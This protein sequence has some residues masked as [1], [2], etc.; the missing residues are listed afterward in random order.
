[1]RFIKLKNLIT[2][3]SG[4]GLGA[5]DIYNFYYLWYFVTTSPQ[6]VNTD[7][8][9]EVMKNYLY[10]LKNK[11]IVLFKNILAKQIAKYIQRNRVDGDFPKDIINSLGTLSS[12]ELKKLMAKTF[13]SDMK[14]RNDVWDMVAGFVYNLENATTSEKMFLYIN[15]LNNAVH[16]TGTQ[17][18][19]KFPNFY[20]ELKPA[21]DAVDRIKSGNQWELMKG[22]VKNKDIRSLLNQDNVDN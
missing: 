11:Y 13:R 8:G 9:R 18:M 17:V 6:S 21:F 10:N 4:N 12:S 3:S 22:L 1:M 5:S 14:R 20:S 15:Q 7:F 19:T 2:E 16:N